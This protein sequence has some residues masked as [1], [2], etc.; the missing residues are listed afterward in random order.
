[1]NPILIPTSDFIMSSTD[2]SDDEISQVSLPSSELIICLLNHGLIDD[3]TRPTNY[4]ECH[5]LI[6]AAVQRNLF[7]I[8]K[9]LV[10]SGANVNAKGTYGNTPL[11]LAAS[12]GSE[13]IVELLLTHK[14]KVNVMCPGFWRSSRLTPLHMAIYNENI[15]VVKLLLKAG[16]RLKD[17]SLTLNWAFDTG[18][19][20]IAD[21]LISENANFN[22]DNK[23][24]VL[25][26]LM[27]AI[28]SGKK[29]LVEKIL[30]Q[31]VDVNTKTDNGI[32]ILTYAKIQKQN[33][34]ANLLISKG[35][36]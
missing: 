17:L 10:D 33:D 6:H 25:S 30:E 23:H 24:E 20:E 27:I 1:M 32:S 29:Q 15:A 3:Q 18:N 5:K 35:G 12:N 4:K 13:D 16:A 8:V 36:S 14:A 2:G 22:V 7:K 11:H 21:I 31:G 19:E 9:L 28:Q 34:I 26:L